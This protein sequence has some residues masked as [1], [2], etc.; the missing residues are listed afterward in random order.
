MIGVR[1]LGSANSRGLRI[2]LLSAILAGAVTGGGALRAHTG[3]AATATTLR[4]WYGTEDA[5]EVPWAHQLAQRFMAQHRSMHVTLTTYNLDDL[6]D[7]MQLALSAGTPPDLVYTTPRGP[8][9]PAY[10][11]AGKLLDL[12][13]AAR[14][15]GWA[16]Q[17]RPGLLA[18]YKRLL[19]A[20]RR[21]AGAGPHHRRP[22]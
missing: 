3:A 4:I 16:A 5:T 20:H 22:P 14:Q 12:S 19:A 15:R 9:L 6:N 1:H 8:G 2:S 17:L 11:R 7:K 10:V 13:S 21:R 18:E